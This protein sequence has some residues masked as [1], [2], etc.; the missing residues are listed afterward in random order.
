MPFKNLKF[1]VAEDN[2]MNLLIIKKFLEKWDIHIDVAE[3]GEKA[4]EMAKKNAYNMI[5]M[6]LQMPL[7]DGYQAAK[8]IREAAEPHLKNIPII[9]ITA[10]A[11]IDAQK[12]I[13]NYG[14]N[15]YITKPFSETELFE[16]IKKHI[17]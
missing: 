2:K 14:I 6:D 10:T 13:Y 7:L 8:Q 15:A 3:N 11:F 4:I 5:L 12:E 9:A 1:L 17:K 16:V